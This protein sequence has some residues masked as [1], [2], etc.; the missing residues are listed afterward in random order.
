METSGKVLLLERGRRGV[1]PTQAGTA[2]VH[3]ARAVF[4]QIAQLQSE[5]GTYAKGLRA[6]IGVWGN[7]AAVSEFLPER[8]A[9][10]MAAHP[11]VD[12]DIKERQSIDIASG[13]SSGFA[14]IG[15]LS[16]AV[17]TGD[18]ALLP[19]AIDRLVVVTAKESPLARQERVFFSHISERPIIGLTVGALQDHIDS[20]A[21][22]LGVRLNIRT[23]LRSFDG[24]CHLAA[25]GVGIGIVPETAA[26]RCRRSA[27][28][29]IVPL[30][31]VWATRRLF[32]CIRPD[33]K[34]LPGLTRNLVEHLASSDVDVTNA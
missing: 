10:W 26:H 17:D 2:L 21:S 6:T 8:L 29:A 12:V 5:I 27:S 34:N 3:H 4:Q 32:I 20:Q 31:D 24:I 11:Q 22:R 9:P 28:I 14:D 13:V 25:E 1:T 33:S 18:L 16:D 7:T 19:F 23:R 15:I 30:A